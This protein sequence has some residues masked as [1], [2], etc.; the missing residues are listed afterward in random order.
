M[1]QQ[2]STDEN[3]TDGGDVATGSPTPGD[4]LRSLP[5]EAKERGS[6]YVSANAMQAR[7]FSIYDAAAAAEDAL[8]LVQQQ[9][10]ITLN[11]SFYEADEIATMAEQLDTLLAVDAELSAELSAGLAA[12]EAVSSE[13]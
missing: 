2:N 10:T 8:E 1:E 4:L 11:R 5:G 7:L 6:Q 12:E 13:D 9:L 3:T